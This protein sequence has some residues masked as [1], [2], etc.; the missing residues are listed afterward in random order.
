MSK[1]LK[2]RLKR[3]VVKLR[4]RRCV[5]CGS[6]NRI[7]RDHIIPLSRGGKGRKNNI[8]PLCHSCNQKKGNKYKPES[9]TPGPTPDRKEG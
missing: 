3:K 1:K 5:F 4:T 7:T 2:K 8:Q 9:A 6:P